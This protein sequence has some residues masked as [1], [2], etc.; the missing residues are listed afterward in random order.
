[1]AV[2]LRLVR[3]DWFVSATVKQR[4]ES[5]RKLEKLAFAWLRSV[6]RNQKIYFPSLHWVLRIESGSNPS[7]RHFHLYVGGLQNTGKSARMYCMHLY[8]ALVGTVPEKSPRGTM[9]IRRYR[10]SITSEDYILKKKNTSEEW[11]LRNCDKLRVSQAAWRLSHKLTRA[12]AG[13]L[14]SAG[15]LVTVSAE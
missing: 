13:G 1:M 6:C 2:V 4:D 7:H 5:N 3:W 15:P 14:K 10:S 11:G 9:R 12:S 8:D